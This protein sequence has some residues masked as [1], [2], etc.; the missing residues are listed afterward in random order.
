M[1]LGEPRQKTK[2]VVREKK[3]DELNFNKDEKFD[4]FKSHLGLR[5][6][7]PNIDLMAL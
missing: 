2:R 5:D 1:R 3:I 6:M 4:F 7:L